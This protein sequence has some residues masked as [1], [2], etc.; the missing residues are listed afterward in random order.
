MGVHTIW[1]IFNIKL[2]YSIDVIFSFLVWLIIDLY[3]ETSTLS[4]HFIWPRSIGNQI[5]PCF[6]GIVVST[7]A[8]QIRPD[9]PHYKVSQQKKKDVEVFDYS[10]F[11]MCS[12]NFCYIAKWPSHSYVCMYIYTHSFSH[13]VFR[14]VLSQETGFSSLCCTAGPRCLSILNSL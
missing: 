8:F 6:G 3:L 9:Y 14:L 12:V 7:A 4:P 13:S 11:T 1:K 5:R 10:W 2:I